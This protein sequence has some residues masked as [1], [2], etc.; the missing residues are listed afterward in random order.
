[1]SSLS[2]AGGNMRF[3]VEWPFTLKG[4]VVFIFLF[5]GMSNLMFSRLSQRSQCERER[6]ENEVLFSLLGNN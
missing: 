6:G 4:L 2:L 5:L 3:V 1:M